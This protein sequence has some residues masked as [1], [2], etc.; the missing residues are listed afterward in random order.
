MLSTYAYAWR[1]C[2]DLPQVRIVLGAKI[3]AESIREGQDAYFECVVDANPWLTEI[4]WVFDG[5]L[6]YSDPSSGIIVSNQSL[7]LQRVRRQSR[8][9]YWC[10]A[11][12]AI[13]QSESEYFY[14]K[15]QCK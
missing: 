10:T 4:A 1:A 3:D 6:L 11:R 9:N 2:T 7:V 8:G 14:L 12:N 15:V 5:K 13:G